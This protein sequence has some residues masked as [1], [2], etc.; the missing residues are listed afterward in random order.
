MKNMKE[1]LGR[2][3]RG[4]TLVE[5]IIVI[6]II[7]I[8]AAIAVPLIT[9]NLGDARQRAYSAE[10]E[11]IQAAVDAQYGAPGNTR[12]QGTRQYAIMGVDQTGSTDLWSDSDSS[13]SLTSPGNPVRGTAGGSPVWVDS[14]SDG[15]RNISTEENLNAEA[16]S[17]GATAGGWHV[18]KVTK[19]VTEYVVDTRDYFVDFDKL[20]SGGYLPDVPESASLDNRPSGSSNVYDGSYS[21]Y[22]DTNGRVKSLLYF[23]PVATNS[24]YQEVFP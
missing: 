13:T 7:G 16:Y 5:L 3:E 21:W 6:A 11:Q 24:G 18:V 22:V 1:R 20:I 14:D 23:F 10:T 4:F 12:F 15:D 8:L 19:Q 9:N 2:G 17:A